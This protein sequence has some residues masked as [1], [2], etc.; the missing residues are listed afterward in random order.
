MKRTVTDPDESGAQYV[1]NKHGI[2]LVQVYYEPDE[3]V[4]GTPRER[5]KQP[6]VWWWASRVPQQ[7][8]CGTAET[9][10][11]ALEKALAWC[12]AMYELWG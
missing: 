3:K 2:V 6:G 1:L 11:K 7:S 4:V 12:D 9:R 10:E 8:L 5:L